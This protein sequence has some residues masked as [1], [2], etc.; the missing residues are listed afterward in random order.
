[1]TAIKQ[2][3]VTSAAHMANLARYLDDGRAIA[4][5]SQ[6]LA[7]ERAWSR[8]MD[9]TREAYGHNEPSRAGAKNTYM[10]HQV[11]AWNPD[12]VELNGGRMT[13][14]DCMEF[15]RQWVS[16]RY[17]D[18]EAVWVLHRERCAAD[19]T[20]R[21]AAH[22]GINRTDLSTGLRLNEGRAKEAKVARAGAMRGV[23]RRWGLRQMHAGERNCL[24]HARQPTRQER[25]M[26]ARGVTSDKQYVRDAVR[27]S[28]AEVRGRD[29][30]NK[31]RALARA[32]DEKGVAM[33]RSADGKELVF[34]RK[35]T[36]LE[37]RGNKLGRGYSAAGVLR[38]LGVRMGVELV[39][40]SLEGMER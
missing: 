21:Y 20:E 30:A 39:R 10:F 19:G 28:M 18:Q 7:D 36:G 2:V 24:A 23:D 15:V 11:I 27:A 3:A 5:G 31:V 1:M 38:G 29:E 13:K 25:E 12:E 35:R 34:E 32:L 17:P 16:E 40:A 14:E 26:A 37:V 4:R 22:V 6:N 8:E 33:R 9:A